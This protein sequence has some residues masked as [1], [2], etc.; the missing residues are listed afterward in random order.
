MVRLQQGGS[1]EM[2]RSN[3]EDDDGGGKGNDNGLQLWLTLPSEGSSQKFLYPTSAFMQDAISWETRAV[4]G[5]TLEG[6][7]EIPRSDSLPIFTR[8]Q[9]DRCV[10]NRGE[11]LTT[12]DFSGGDA[13]TAGAIG[14]SEGQ[15]EKRVVVDLLSF[16]SENELIADG[17]GKVPLLVGADAT[18]VMHKEDDLVQKNTSVLLAERT[19][20]ARG[21]MPASGCRS[22]HLLQMSVVGVGQQRRR[23]DSSSDHI[24][25]EFR[26][27]KQSTL[28]SP[29]QT[30]LALS[31]P[32]R[33]RPPP[34][35][36]S[37][38]A[39]EKKERT[40]DSRTHPLVLSLPSPFYYGAY[41]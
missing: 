26:D 31:H 30:P 9:G 28:C 15:R 3:E 12:V 11:G 39:E 21:T 6:R 40:Q 4:V 5:D 38:G 23:E 36:V 24:N 32:V 33:L 29:P 20:A 13:A 37:V 41:E 7:P 17:V 25:S 8:C 14:R 2:R 27:Q 19:K 22:R 34:F 10:V 16:D 35:L 18:V 1:T